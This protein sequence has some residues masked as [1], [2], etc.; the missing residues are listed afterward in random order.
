MHSVCDSLFCRLQR[1]LHERELEEVRQ[2]LWELKLELERER[3]AAPKPWQ[4]KLKKKRH[5]TKMIGDN[6]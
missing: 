5:K 1:R 4:P 2:R 6:K 3:A